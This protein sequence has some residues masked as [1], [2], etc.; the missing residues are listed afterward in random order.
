VIWRVTYRTTTGRP[1]AEVEHVT[2]LDA[3]WCAGMSLDPAALTSPEAAA[4][5]L[6]LGL[7]ANGDEEAELITVERR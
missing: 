4:W 5:Y 1:P 2:D 7:A 6:A 3:D